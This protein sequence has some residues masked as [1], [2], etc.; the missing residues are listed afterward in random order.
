MDT[1]PSNNQVLLEVKNLQ[2]FFPIRKGFFKRVVGQVRAVD[3]VSFY[4][5]EGETLGLVGESGCG[6]T[7]TAR[8]ILRALDPTGG[9]ILYRTQAGQT[10]DIATLP[11][12][13][14]RPLRREMQMIFQDP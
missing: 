14:M 6:K 9:Q 4:I 2:K 3:D 1:T 8:C 10:V 11:K 13:E 5:N 7:T 12:G